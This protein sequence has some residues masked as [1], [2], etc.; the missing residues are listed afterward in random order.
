MDPGP[1]LVLTT[2]PNETAARALASG[3]VE[4]RL[5]ACVQ[6]IP[7]V[8]SIYRWEGVVEQAQEVL[9][10][11]KTRRG[12]LEAIEAFLDREHPYEVPEF[13]VLEPESLGEAYRAWLLAETEK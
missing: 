12:H 10:M 11:I 13:A 7:G 3:L 4:A 8:N 1:R 5:A 2:T 9:L 6:C